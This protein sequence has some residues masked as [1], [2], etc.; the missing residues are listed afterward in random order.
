GQLGQHLAGLRVAQDRA[1]S[2]GT[3]VAAGGAIGIDQDPSR[4][5]LVA[6]GRRVS[7]WRVTSM[8]ARVMLMPRG[9]A[10][11]QLKMVRQR[12]TPSASAMIS[13]RSSVAWSRLSKMNRCALTIAAGPT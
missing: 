7:I 9:Q 13:S 3:R 2:G 5:D 4:R 12:H 11:T 10:S 8:I 1:K 6:H